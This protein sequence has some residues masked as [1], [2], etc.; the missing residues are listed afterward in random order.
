MGNGG[1][2]TYDHLHIIHMLTDAGPGL[3][4]ETQ[5]DEKTKTLGPT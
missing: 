5:D 2:L 1:M 3:E 4:D